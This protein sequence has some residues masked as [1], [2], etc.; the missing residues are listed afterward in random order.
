MS[1]IPK[2]SSQ[3]IWKSVQI[4]YKSGKKWCPT[5]F[6]FKNWRPKSTKKHGV[7]FWGRSHQT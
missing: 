3:H 5:L 1:E 2:K 4:P 6:D 7:L